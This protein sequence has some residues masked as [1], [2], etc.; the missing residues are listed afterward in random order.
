MYTYHTEKRFFYECLTERTHNVV[1]GARE[2]V[3]DT[4]CTNIFRNLSLLE[5]YA[6]RTVGL[7]PQPVEAQT[8]AKDKP[9]LP[10]D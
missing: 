2:G 5:V 4:F 1:Q 8:P 7:H 3:A 10:G 9:R 6:P